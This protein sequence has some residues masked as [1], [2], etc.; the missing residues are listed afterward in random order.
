MKAAF[1]KLVTPNKY[2]LLR[3]LFF[4]FLFVLFFVFIIYV[5]INSPA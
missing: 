4:S 5:L 3:N 1:K 2:T